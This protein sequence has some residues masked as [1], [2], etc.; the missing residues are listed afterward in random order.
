MS[1]SANMDAAVQAATRIAGARTPKRPA[2]GLSTDET[3]NMA[4][5]LVALDVTAGLSLDLV[6]ALDALEDG[7]LPPAAAA[8]RLALV[9]ALV[10][11]GYAAL[12]TPFNNEDRS[13]G[14]G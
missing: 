13:N 2:I 4:S 1:I 6:V 7:V 5:A 9:N 3:V 12:E 14:N 11:I 8:A 10:A